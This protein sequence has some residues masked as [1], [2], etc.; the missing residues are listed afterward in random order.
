MTIQFGCEREEVLDALCDADLYVMNSAWEGFGLVLLEAMLNGCEWAANA[1]AGASDDL[2]SMGNVYSSQENLVSLLSSFTRD[3]AKAKANQARCL[4]SFTV[5]S[6]VDQ[7]ERIVDAEIRAGGRTWWRPIVPLSS[8]TGST[9]DLTALDEAKAS[10]D[11]PEGPAR[12]LPSL[13]EDS[14]SCPRK[15]F[16]T[17]LCG[18]SDYVEGVITL[19]KSLICVGSTLPLMVAVTPEVTQADRERILKVGCIIRDIQPIE[20]SLLNSQAG[21]FARAEFQLCYS[22]LQLWSWTDLDTVVYLDADAMVMRNVDVLAHVLENQSHQLAWVRDYGTA[23]K[24]NGSARY[25]NAG[26]MVL[27]PSENTYRKLLLGMC[28]DGVSNNGS[29]AEQDLLNHELGEEALQLPLHFNCLVEYFDQPW[30]E[31]VLASDAPAAGSM[32]SSVRTA[33]VEEKGALLDG[34][35]TSMALV[36]APQV[37]DQV[38]QKTLQAPPFLWT[39]ADAKIKPSSILPSI[40]HFTV[41]KPWRVPSQDMRRQDKTTGTTS[42]ALST[43]SAPQATSLA[44]LATKA[45]RA[46]QGMVCEERQMT[47]QVLAS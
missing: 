9:W 46:C 19:R 33:P 37:I 30:L 6:T 3:E 32:I 1:G 4:Q 2:A 8:P 40:I 45:W 23:G 13:D 21:S 22:K 17:L 5:R 44:F 43:Q 10:V 7:I 25:S 47:P 18:R 14:L 27:K 35:T 15:A 26:V 34:K 42:T 38:P 11:P 28:R 24:A 16:A 12:Y 20:L 39:L 41:P 36:N 31:D 29:Y